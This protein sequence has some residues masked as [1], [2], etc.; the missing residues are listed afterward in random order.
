MKRL[1]FLSILLAICCFF[2][3]F[4]PFSKHT[5]TNTE[6]IRTETFLDCPDY[7]ICFTNGKEK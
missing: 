1:S 5:V 3:G 6:E 4:L 7:L 2:A